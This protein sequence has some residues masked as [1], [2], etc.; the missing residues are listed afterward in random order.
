[1]INSSSSF[2]NTQTALHW[3]AKHGDMNMAT[4][5]L[6]ASADVNTKSVRALPLF[7]HF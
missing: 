4:L 1:M 6:E 5:V 7:A 2:L 3:A